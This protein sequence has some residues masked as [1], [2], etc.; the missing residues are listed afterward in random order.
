MESQEREEAAK[1]IARLSKEQVAKLLI[2]MAGMEAQRAITE[3]K[4]K[5]SRPDI[6]HFKKFVHRLLIFYRESS[7]VVMRQ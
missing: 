7:I 1:R 4:R 5:D 3:R 2:F 6:K